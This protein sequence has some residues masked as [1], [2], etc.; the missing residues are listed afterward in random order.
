ML[1]EEIF[2]EKADLQKFYMFRE[3]MTAGDTTLTINDLSLRMNVSYQ[4]SYNIFQELVTDM[5]TLTGM[6]SRAAKKQ[7]STQAD[8]PISIDEYR[9]FL[10]KQA[11][12]FEFV[13]YLVQATNP[14]V[15]KFCQEHFISRSTLLRKTTGVRDLLAKYQ[16]KLSLT[17]TGF[18]GDEKQIRL[19]IYTF[20]WM[21]YHGLAWPFKSPALAVV[22]KQYMQ[23]P[24]ARENQIAILQD[25]LFWGICRLRISHGFVLQRFHRFDE[26]LGRFP[27]AHQYLYSRAM[28][29]GL[30]PAQ[31]RAESEFFI[32]YQLRDMDFN[33]HGHLDRQLY[34]Y[35]TTDDNVVTDYLLRLSNFAKPFLRQ[36]AISLTKNAIL[37]TNLAR[38][39]M[40]YYLLEGEHIKL[41]DF[42]NFTREGYEQTRLLDFLN[43]FV[44]TLPQTGA[45]ASL[46][47]VRH[48]MVHIM[49]YLLI[50]Y[51]QVFKWNELVQVK[52]LNGA[53][54]LA[55]TDMILFLK[56]MNDVEILD[57]NADPQTA[58]LII[59]AVDDPEELLRNNPELHHPHIL[60]WHLDPTETDFYQL[61]ITI[62]HIF[63][64]KLM[65]QV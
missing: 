13:D 44:E 39:V 8:F 61:Y 20:Y 42:F 9:L 10:L 14:S 52:L 23:M 33:D 31:L 27:E 45:Y 15:D 54:G 41:I 16:V 4:Q 34:H 18:V 29:P 5:Q 12:Q 6:T 22:H 48:Q 65:P 60:Y 51:L 21:G 38:V 30:S 32:F 55:N 1:F 59:A 11:I 24:N 49:Y 37:A 62:K 53:N 7:L 19:F 64:D 3:L 17:Q 43:D 40:N 2:V 47:P 28:F 26:V 36:P 50:P 58:D 25:M 46:Y 63:L 35:F 57:D 56:D